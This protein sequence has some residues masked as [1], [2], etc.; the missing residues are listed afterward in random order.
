L[1]AIVARVFYSENMDT[2][3]EMRISALAI[4]RH[5]STR[6]AERVTQRLA[7]A[8]AEAM[9]GEDSPGPSALSRLTGLSHTSVSK[10]AAREPLVA[11]DDRLQTIKYSQLDGALSDTGEKPIRIVSGFEESDVWQGS[12]LSPLFF[13]RDE[14]LEVPHM[15]IQLDSGVW[16]GVQQVQVGYG[17]TGPGNARRALTG[18]VPDDLAMKISEHRYSDVRLDDLDSSIFSASWPYFDLDLPSYQ[19]GRFVVWFNEDDV[20][21]TEHIVGR[22][23]SNFFPTPRSTPLLKAWLDLLRSDEVPEWCSGTIRARVF[24]D[25]TEATKQGFFVRRG[26]IDRFSPTLVIEQG[27]LQLWFALSAAPEGAWLPREAYEILDYAGVYPEK[28]AQE[29]EKAQAPFRRFLARFGF[30]GRQRPSYLD[31]SPD[32]EGALDYIPAETNQLRKG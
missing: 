21:L 1:I 2:D 26:G 10:L 6:H 5:Q 32:G 15:A 17:G 18:L 23:R 20:Q 25:A 14:W 31:I 11:D 4:E 19:D 29:D 13:E 24:L 12:G 27:L 30:E 8:L 22:P 28:L 3:L 7:E 16:I 9:S